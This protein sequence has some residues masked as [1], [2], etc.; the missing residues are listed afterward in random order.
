MT[1]IPVVERLNTD[2]ERRAYHEAKARG[3]AILLCYFLVV[4]I[5]AWSVL[6]R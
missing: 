6:S 4:G 3:A 2:I 5:V 1:R